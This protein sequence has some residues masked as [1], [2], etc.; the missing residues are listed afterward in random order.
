LFT[1]V[2][3]YALVAGNPGRVVGWR[4]RPADDAPPLAPADAVS[5]G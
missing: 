3:P 5:I 4:K 1:T 2:P